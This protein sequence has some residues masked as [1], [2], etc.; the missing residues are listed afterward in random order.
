MTIKLFLEK[1]YNRLRHYHLRIKHS[2]LSW[3]YS[4]YAR[5]HLE[6]TDFCLICNNC[7]GGHLYETLNRPYNTPTIGL[8]FFAEDYLKFTQN[9]DN[10]LKE[11]LNFIKHSRFQEC[12]Q[13]HRKLKYPIGIL[14]NNL[15]IHFL[16][17]KTE[18]EAK[19]KWNRRKIRVDKRNLMILMNDQNRFTDNMMMNFDELSYP[20]VFFSVKPRGGNSVRV[21]RFYNGRTSVGDMYNDKLKVFKDFDLV[22]W[23]KLNAN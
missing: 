2:L 3:I 1:I 10:Y 21:I 15:E 13:E 11:D 5:Y 16:H 8:Y 22:K 6:N 9:L 14:S 4:K 23:I 7:Y 20:K 18:Q 19:E 12:H 17:Y